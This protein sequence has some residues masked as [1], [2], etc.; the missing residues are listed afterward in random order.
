MR[1]AELGSSYTTAQF[2][3]QKDM[4]NESNIKDMVD[5]QF[6]KEPYRNVVVIALTNVRV[7]M[8][9]LHMCSFRHL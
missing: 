1:G 6:N 2:R 4:C 7:S 9:E 3:L 8:R 5:L